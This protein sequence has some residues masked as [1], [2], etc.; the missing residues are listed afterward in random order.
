MPQGV[1]ARVHACEFPLTLPQ[2]MIYACIAEYFTSL[3]GTAYLVFLVDDLDAD[4]TS[5]QTFLGIHPSHLPLTTFPP[6]HPSTLTPHILPSPPPPFPFFPLPLSHPNTPLH[7][8]HI[9]H[10]P[11]HTV[12]P[13]SHPFLHMY[14]YTSH[15][16]RIPTPS[17]LHTFHTLTS[18]HPHIFTSSHP[19]IFTSSHPHIFTSSHP[20]IFTPSRREHPAVR[21]GHCPELALHLRT[22][23]VEEISSGQQDREHHEQVPGWIPTC[24]SIGNL[25]LSCFHTVIHSL[26]NCSNTS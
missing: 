12:P 17:H 4:T 14:V 25:I 5:L 13:L 20:H 11:L 22:Q 21:G 19:H 15:Y 16:T 2:M 1:R 9:L 6:S 7:T 8:P 3:D 23:V 26:T 10:I 24:T 18:S